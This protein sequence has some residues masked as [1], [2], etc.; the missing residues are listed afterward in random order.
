MITIESLVEQGVNVKLEV[1]PTDLKM[2]AESIVQRTI[3]A[4]QEERNTAILQEVEETYLNT[5]Q[6]REIL[7]VCEGTLNTWAKRGYLVPVKVGNQNMYAKSDVRR[8]QTGNKSESVSSY[9]K[10]KNV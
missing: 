2:F 9:C 3:M 10:R 7:N 1:S 8:M 6:V 4:Q 5:K